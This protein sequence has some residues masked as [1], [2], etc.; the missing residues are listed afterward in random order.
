MMSAK[1]SRALFGGVDIGGAGRSSEE[2]RAAG[3]GYTVYGTSNTMG[4]EPAMTTN[5]SGTVSTGGTASDG[6]T[7]R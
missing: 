7:M 3:M 6:T 2:M 1:A 5:A 4:G